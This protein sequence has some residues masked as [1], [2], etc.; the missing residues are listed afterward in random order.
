VA[1]FPLAA[2]AVTEPQAPALPQLTVQSAPRPARSF[3][4]V[5]VNCA[6]PFTWTDAAAGVT[7][8][9]IG[10]GGAMVIVTVAVALGLAVDLATTITVAPDGMLD[11]GV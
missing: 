3:V 7:A 2:C 10:G 8:T 11:G 9:A 6:V 4:T 5:A 1:A